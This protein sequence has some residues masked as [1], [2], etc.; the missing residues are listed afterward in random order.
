DVERVKKNSRTGGALINPAVRS[1]EQANRATAPLKAGQ[2]R[3]DA[4][5]LPAPTNFTFGM[6]DA[7]GALGGLGHDGDIFAL[8]RRRVQS[9]NLPARG[10]HRVSSRIVAR[11]VAADPSSVATLRRVEV[12]T[13]K[14]R[15]R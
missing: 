2:L 6:N 4:L 5:L 7:P 15:S 12:T 13:G 9:N 11:A 1:G 3:Q 14:C 10:G 8:E